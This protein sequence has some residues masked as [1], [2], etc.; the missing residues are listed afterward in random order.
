MTNPCFLEL[1]KQLPKYQPGK[2]F[3]LKKRFVNLFSLWH[4]DRLFDR[5][6]YLRLGQ[7]FEE[8][9]ETFNRDD[10]NVDKLF[11]LV[12]VMCHNAFAVCAQAMGNLAKI[13]GININMKIPN[14][15]ET[16]SFRQISEI[17]MGEPT[18]VDDLPISM[19]PWSWNIFITDLSKTA[20]I[21]GT[22]PSSSIK[23]CDML[24]A[25]SG[26]FYIGQWKVRK[27]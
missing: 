13:Y 7:R 12:G 25:D 21:K 27:K 2:A 16:I 26:N 5:N 14:G 6:C 8:H 15:E 17:L 3:V 19:D 11:E 24:F 18:D 22:L 23:V 20:P 9:F 10:R 1:V 4:S